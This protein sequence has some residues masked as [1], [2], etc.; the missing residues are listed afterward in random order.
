MVNSRGLYMVLLA[1]TFAVA[2]RTEGQA[3]RHTW[4]GIV[5]ASGV[6]YGSS[7]PDGGPGGIGLA[8]GIQRAI[9]P[10]VGV[11]VA[12]QF[13]WTLFGSP[14]PVC[15]PAPGGGCL[16]PSVVPKQILQF[17]IAAVVRPVRT[18][19]LDVVGGAAI[20]T[21]FGPR[22]NRTPFAVVD[23][24]SRSRG[25]LIGGL[26]VG[27]GRSYRAPRVFVSRTHLLKDSW[28][29]SSLT[30]AGFVFPF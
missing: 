22:E 11:R 12:S 24:T 29:L 3:S 4:S 6:G 20:V 17:S 8:L 28:S 27:L 7:G 25:S 21:P 10:Q 14:A 15:H 16:G 1:A 30:M 23:S 19:P 13:V 26:E 2:P 5:G 18:F 9:T